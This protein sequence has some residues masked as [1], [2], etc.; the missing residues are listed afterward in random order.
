MN[1][2]PSV[3][4]QPLSW[5]AIRLLRPRQW[6]KNA[7]AAHMSTAYVLAP[8]LAWAATGVVKFVLKSLRAGRPAFDR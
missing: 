5:P 7:F 8:L 3:V 6:I 1:S 4:D 2:V